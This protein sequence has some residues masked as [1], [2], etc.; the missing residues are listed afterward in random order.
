MLFA[1]MFSLVVLPQVLSHLKI[2]RL[3][4][5]ERTK[6]S[7]QINT[8]LMAHKHYCVFVEKADG[9]LLFPFTKNQFPQG[10]LTTTLISEVSIEEKDFE[11]FMVNEPFFLRESLFKLDPFTSKS[12]QVD[13]ETYLES[14]LDSI[15]R[16]IETCPKVIILANDHIMLI[17]KAIDLL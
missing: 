11:Q 4:L 13:L 15:S 5:P 12:S 7:I 14:N 17:E 1:L 8:F 2:G 3:I 6:K 16:V 9:F 10:N